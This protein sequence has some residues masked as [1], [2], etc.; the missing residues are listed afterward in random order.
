MAIDALFEGAELEQGLDVEDLRLL[1]E[2]V[3]LD[4]PGARRQDACVLR[5][6]AFVDAELVVVVVVRD[7][8]EAGQLLAGRAERALDG[9]KLGVGMHGGGGRENFGCSLDGGSGC[10]SNYRG[11]EGSAEKSTAVQILVFGCDRR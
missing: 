11:R 7:V 1:D 8:L 6:I 10:T 4:G 3:H 5:R 9:V 2:A